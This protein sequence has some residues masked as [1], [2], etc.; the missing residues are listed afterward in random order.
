MQRAPAQRPLDGPVQILNENLTPCI[1]STAPLPETPIASEPIVGLSSDQRFVL[2]P[3]LGESLGS[4]VVD[5]RRSDQ[6]MR[7]RHI[8][9]CQ[10][11]AGDEICYIASCDPELTIDDSHE[12]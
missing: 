11:A 10:M 7:G 8:K 12:P 1:R 2:E 9:S 5:N 4:D 6:L 3:T